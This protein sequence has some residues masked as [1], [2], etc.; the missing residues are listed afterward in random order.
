M[1]GLPGLPFLPYSTC[2]W[3]LG[4]ISRTRCPA[5]RTATDENEELEN[6]SSFFF[7][8]KFKRDRSDLRML[9]LCLMESGPIW[10][11]DGDFRSF[12]IRHFCKSLSDATPGKIFE[13]L[14]ARN[15]NIGVSGRR[16]EVF[17]PF[18][19]FTIY[20]IISYYQNYT[21]WN[22]GS[23]QNQKLSQRCHGK[24]YYWYI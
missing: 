9:T 19:C 10:L 8:E 1:R 7:L 24:K 13:C 6:L 4:S 21:V 14:V 3:L 23:I 12:D 15:R 2:A 18:V 11:R 16:Y 20:S 17:V 5:R 22:T